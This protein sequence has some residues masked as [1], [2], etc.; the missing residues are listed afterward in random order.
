MKLVKKTGKAKGALHV[1]VLLATACVAGGVEAA[2]RAVL[3]DSDIVIYGSTPAALSAAVQAKRMGRSAVIVCPETRIGGL[4]TGGLGQTDI[5]NKAAFGGIALDFYKDVAKYYG[6]PD[7]LVVQFPNE[8]KR[9]ATSAGILKSESKWTFEPS[10][11]LSILEGWEKRDGLDIR[12]NE[13]LDRENGVEKKDG[14]QMFISEFL[15]I[16]SCIKRKTS[17]LKDAPA[18]LQ[19]TK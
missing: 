8:K 3:V 9:K 19:K 13:W 16:L 10:V 15:T 17:V 11:A 2:S 18:D 6:N 4:T 5:G 7:H 12:R 1:A 14:L